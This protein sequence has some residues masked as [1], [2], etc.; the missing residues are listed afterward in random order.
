VLPA[1]APQATQSTVA[2][3]AQAPTPAK[4]RQRH[5][6]ADAPEISVR[7][8][9]THAAHA[10][11]LAWE[12]PERRSGESEREYKERA[13]T[14]LLA[15]Y[16]A[17]APHQHFVTAHTKIVFGDGDA[18]ARL[19]FV[20]EAPGADE[21]RLG[22]PFVGRSGEKLNQMIAGMG[23][24]RQQVYICN[25]LKTRPPN[26]ATPTTSEAERCA[27]Y[28]LEQLSIIGPEAIVTLGLPAVRTLLQTDTAMGRMR[29]K[30]AELRLP[31]GRR[32]PVMPTYHPAYL[33]RNYTEQTRREIWGDLQM[34]MTKLGLK[35]AGSASKP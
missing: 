20:G 35:P 25:V 5:A 23:L 17:D 16:E 10:R 18:S 9:T 8:T 12:R 15:K 6:Q 4:D 13:L 1:A 24:S 7:A 19:V 3:P 28:L 21:D 2:P 26:N 34:V 32:V 14:A 22:V 30:W 31:D 27:P 11:S 29:G 33:L